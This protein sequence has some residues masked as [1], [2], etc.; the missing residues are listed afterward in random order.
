[1]LEAASEFG[2]DSR[3]DFFLVS[4]LNFYVLYV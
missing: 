4:L 3:S 2:F 1:M